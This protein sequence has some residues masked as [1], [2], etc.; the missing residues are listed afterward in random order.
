MSYIS[1]EKFYKKPDASVFKL[2]LTAAGRANE[3]A[4]GAQPLVKTPSKKVT[5]VALEEI[6]AGVVRYELKVK[7]KKV[8]E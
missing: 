6:A 4:Q 2:V 1:L 8:K 7:S 5:T 3:L